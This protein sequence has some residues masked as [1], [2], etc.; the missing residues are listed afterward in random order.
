MVTFV[1]SSVASRH[2]KVVSQGDSNFMVYGF[3]EDRQSCNF[4]S[5][6]EGWPVK[7]GQHT[8]N[9]GFSRIIIM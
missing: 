1:R 8:S 5:I 2:F 4:P 6:L 7:C 9:T 3:V